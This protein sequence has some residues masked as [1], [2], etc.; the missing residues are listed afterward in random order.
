MKADSI[1][2]HLKPYSI[3][4]KRKTTVNHAFASALAPCSDY[5]ASLVGDA[6][7]TLGQ[8]PNGEL[9]CVYCG[10]LAQ[11][12]DHLT[13]LVKD[14]QL[15]GY[16][17]QIGNLVPGCRDC[18]SRKGNMDWRLFVAASVTEPRRSSLTRSLELYQAQFA[19]PVDMATARS[20]ESA[21][22]ARY[23]EIR[24]EI[25]SL[26]QEADTLAATLRR[27]VR[28]D[29]QL[30]LSRRPRRAAWESTTPR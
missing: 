3:Y 22:W 28:G 23:D 12:W 15:H 26:M 20:Q 21:A 6:L 27:C 24:H 19:T 2:A 9:L 5:D 10:A 8:D 11:T 13:G 18:N 1:K 4:K 29:E 16:G 7:K 14:S 30:F 17:H 25:H